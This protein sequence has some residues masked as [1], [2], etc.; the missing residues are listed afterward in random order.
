[1]LNAIKFYQ[2]LHFNIETS[3]STNFI[4]GKKYVGSSR[5]VHTK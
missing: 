4:V 2:I 3:V 1:M 5:C